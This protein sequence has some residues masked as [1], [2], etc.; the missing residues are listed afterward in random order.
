[1]TM[2]T[3]VVTRRTSGAAED[4]CGRGGVKGT[5]GTLSLCKHIVLITR[6]KSNLELF[7]FGGTIKILWQYL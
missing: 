1:M 5:F 2:V 7:F 6:I 3:T 4:A